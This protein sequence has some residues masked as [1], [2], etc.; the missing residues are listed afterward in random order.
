[1]QSASVPYLKKI[2]KLIHQLSTFKNINQK[3]RLIPLH[4]TT[5]LII[6]SDSHQH[7]QHNTTTFQNYFHKE[8]NI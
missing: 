1:M 2:K 3:L 6:F 5:E 8:I 4:N 7:H